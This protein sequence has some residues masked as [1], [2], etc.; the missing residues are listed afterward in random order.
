MKRIAV[1]LGVL[2]LTASC[3]AQTPLTLQ[4][5]FKVGL[6][7]SKA[8]KISELSAVSARAKYNQV[9]ANRWASLSFQG[10]YTRL[11][12]IPPSLLTLPVSIPGYG[13][14]FQISP[15][16][17]DNYDLELSLKQPLFTGFQL[18]NAS[19]AARDN[20]EASGYDTK[21]DRSNLKV[22][23]ATA[24]WHV[25]NAVQAREFMKENLDRTRSHYQQ[26]KNMLAQG[27][28]T[29]SDVLSAKVQ[30][31]NSQLMLMNA[32]NNVQLAEV[33]LNNV[34]GVPLETRYDIKSVP[35]AGDTTAPELSK[36]LREALENRS[37]L[38]SLHL[39]AK[40]AAAALAAAWGSYLPQVSLVGNLYYQKP[41]QRIFPTQNV[42][43]ETWDASLVVSL[44]IWNWGQT[45]SKIDEARVQKQQA[46]LAEEQTADAVYLDVTRSY[47]NFKQAKD[48]IGVAETT[49][50]DAQESYRISD[51]KFK[52]GLVTNTDLMDAEVSLLQAKLNYSQALTD[53]E[54]ARINLEK[55][56]GQL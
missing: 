55:A 20:S 30:V 18:E 25:Y 12:E 43:K 51:Q 10:R 33:A 17:Y 3:F 35:Q 41:N 23:I 34:L 31:S 46:Q 26:A 5:A 1:I 21:T 44:P 11:S 16:V 32:D 2:S 37:E 50:K 45:Q 24:Y 39:K 19:K 15:N 7:N 13:N 6:E 27:M 47:L 29:E 52:V 8:L 48:K 53:L 42:F 22:Q 38:H 28:L 14:T 49:V 56:T 4:E 9:N 40:A 36:M 54:I